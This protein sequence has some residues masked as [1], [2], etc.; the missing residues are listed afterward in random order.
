[1]R[2]IFRAIAG[3]YPTAVFDAPV[4]AIGGKHG[5][6]LMSPIIGASCQKKGP[7]GPK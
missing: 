4:A 2:D 1:V 3:S 5:D 7:Q 6:N